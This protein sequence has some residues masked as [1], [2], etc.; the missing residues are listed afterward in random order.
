M[1][2]EFA[3]HGGDQSQCWH[4]NQYYSVLQP[5]GVACIPVVIDLTSFGLLK[6]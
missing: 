1:T 5:E 3:K 2:S 6:G 4:S